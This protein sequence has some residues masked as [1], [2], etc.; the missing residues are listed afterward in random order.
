MIAESVLYPKIDFAWQRH[1]S[2]D[3]IRNQRFF[4]VF[5]LKL[6]P[7][8]QLLFAGDAYDAHFLLLENS[9]MQLAGQVFLFSVNF[10]SSSASCVWSGVTGDVPAYSTSRRSTL[11]RLW[12]SAAWT[13]LSSVMEGLAWPKNRAS[14]TL[15]QRAGSSFVFRW[16]AIKPAIYGRSSYQVP[17]PGSK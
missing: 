1:K 3:F 15:F 7:V 10:R 8:M 13:Y 5:A 14:V 2:A 9:L 17:I 6:F 11:P 12:S 16:F 4:F